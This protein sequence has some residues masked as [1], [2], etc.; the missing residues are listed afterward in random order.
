V[1]RQDGT[2]ILRDENQKDVMRWNIS[3]AWPTKYTG[4]SF[5]AT[6]NEIAF[7]SV[8]IAYESMELDR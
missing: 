4:P 1:Q 3:R 5:N 6:N 8:E 2:V 7:E